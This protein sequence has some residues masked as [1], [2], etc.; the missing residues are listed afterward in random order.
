MCH[1][2][3]FSYSLTILPW[4]SIYKYINNPVRLISDI[5]LKAQQFDYRKIHGSQQD[6]MKTL[7][8]SSVIQC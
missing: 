7:V 2:Q 6:I 5:Y 3:A 1:D 4:I 8:I